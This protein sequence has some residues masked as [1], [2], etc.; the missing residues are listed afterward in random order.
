[1]RKKNLGGPPSKDVILS[2]AKGPMHLL[3]SLPLTKGP[4]V[5]QPAKPAG[6]RMTVFE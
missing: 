5:P 1:M 6:L 4:Q 2:N 3:A